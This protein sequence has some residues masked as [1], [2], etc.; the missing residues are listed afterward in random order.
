[1]RLE[2]SVL[3]YNLRNFVYTRSLE[4]RPRFKPPIVN[5][6]Q[7]T[8]VS[9]GRASIERRCKLCVAQRKVDYVRAEL[10]EFNQTVPRIPHFA[11]TGT[12]LRIGVQYPAGNDW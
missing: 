3:L 5:Y 1:V 6:A 7:R 8:V 10:T 11:D 2:G 12:R 4:Q 9:L